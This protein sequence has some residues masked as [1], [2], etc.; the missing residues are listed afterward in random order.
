[1]GRCSSPRGYIITAQALRHVIVH[2]S[3]IIDQKCIK[4]LAN[5]G[6]RKFIKDIELNKKVVI[7][8]SDLNIV[9]ASMLKYVNNLLGLIKDKFAD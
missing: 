7:D 2:N 4:Q 9:K 1:L 3:E 8:T 6:S 5:A